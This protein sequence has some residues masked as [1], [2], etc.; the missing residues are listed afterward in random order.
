M[1]KVEGRVAS[2]SFNVVIGEQAAKEFPQNSRIEVKIRFCPKE[3]TE[4]LSHNPVPRLV[5]FWRCFRCLI[6]LSVCISL[7][8]V[9][10]GYITQDLSMPAFATGAV[11]GIQDGAMNRLFHKCFR[12]IVQRGID[13]QRR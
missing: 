3:L 2:I 6:Q 4:K 5:H 7:E 8:L 10:V 13:N 11:K 9:H 1:Y 12:A